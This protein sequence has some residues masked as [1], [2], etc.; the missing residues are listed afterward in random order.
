MD[1]RKA[2]KTM[3]VVQEAADFHPAGLIL[4]SEMEKP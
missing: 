2:I 4:S 1:A 3:V